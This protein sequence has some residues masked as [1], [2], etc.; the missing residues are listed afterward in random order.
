MT[1][2]FTNLGQTVFEPA[3]GTAAITF[4]FTVSASAQARFVSFQ[5]L[6][7][8]T[9]AP[10]GVTWTASN[11]DFSN[12]Y[13]S[14]N[15]AAGQTTG[16]VTFMVVQDN[17]DEG[18]ETF[19]LYYYDSAD[20]SSNQFSADQ[21][22]YNYIA[23]ASAAQ[24]SIAS[25]SGAEGNAGTTFIDFTVT[26]SGSTAGTAS[27]TYTIVNG[28]SAGGAGDADFAF[29]TQNP[30]SGSVSF[31]AGASTAT[32][33]VPIAGDFV[34]EGNETFTVMLSGA[35]GAS[36][37][38]ATAT[39]TITNDDATGSFSVADVTV[40]EGDTLSTSGQF[41]VTRTNGLA[42]A[43][44]GYT[45]V[46]AGSSMQTTATFGSDYSASR[47]GTLT[48]A[49]GQT[50]ATVP[51]TVLGDTVAEGNETFRL[52]LSTPSDNGT[53]AR[54]VGTATIVDNDGTPPPVAPNTPGLQQGTSGG[55]VLIST[56]QGNSILAGG[57]GDDTYLVYSQ[58]DVV[59]EAVNEGNDI[60]YTTVSYSLG[61]NQVEAMSVADQ[62][63]TGA[64]NLIGNYVSQIIVG[65]YGDNVLNGGSGGIDTL[66]GLFGNDTYAVGDARTVIVEQ[67]GQGSDTAVTSVSY[68]LGAG[69]SVEVFAAQNAASTTGLRLGGNELAQT[70][71]GTAGAD[72]ISG[73]GGRDVLLGGAGADT[74]VIGTV[75]T[76]NV[77]VLAD[78][79]AGTDRIG[80]T[81]SAFNVGTSLDAAE[82]VAG[83]AAT[84]ADQRVIYDAGTGQLFY[85]ADGNGAGAAVLFAQVVPGTAITAVSFDVV[86]P[87]ATIA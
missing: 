9:G 4:N 65:N 17:R 12:P 50:S 10:A 15:I 42:S 31:A 74:F 83:T 76:G 87:T 33:R 82:F 58:G 28:A 66:V 72:T 81:S 75:A 7:D 27:A 85:D 49:A 68:T 1:V 67:A 79:V 55:D 21:N 84:T 54:G 48:F 8:V 3:S 56:N 57:R 69:V 2:Q 60:L 35:T 71:A 18:I 37:A 34:I 44:I 43:T 46:D 5:P 16:S 32:V 52:Q 14:V 29:S 73:G 53:I 19:G 80:L 61:E 25:A 64:I 30:R 78:F 77:A 39:G 45:I 62:M 6:T 51:F 22:T 63:T 23:D 47:S 13:Q 11:A 59:I 86:V 41:V 26:R 38:T 40:A 70:I 20:A 36:I 24:L